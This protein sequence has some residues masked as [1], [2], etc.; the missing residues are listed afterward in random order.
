M[1]IPQFCVCCEYMRVCVKCT[2]TFTGMSDKNESNRM[3]NV[4]FLLEPVPTDVCVA[5][6]YLLQ[7]NSGFQ[8]RSV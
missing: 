2:F 7:P 8:L 4:N 1:V 5:T 3:V 6:R